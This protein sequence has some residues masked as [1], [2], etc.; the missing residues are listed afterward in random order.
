[1]ADD[2]KF[3]FEYLESCQFQAGCDQPAVARVWHKD[4]RSDTVFVC[5]RHLDELRGA[6][7]ELR[8]EDVLQSDLLCKKCGED[9]AKI[10]IEISG[11]R[12]KASCVSCGAYIKW[13]GKADLNRYRMMSG[14]IL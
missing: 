11:G 2:A 8:D 13:I 9:E 3:Q 14:Q 12:T 4:D 6:L 10:M 5:Q 7:E 1:M